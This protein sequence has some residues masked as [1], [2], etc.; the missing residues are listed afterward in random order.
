MTAA[1][2]SI[3]GIGGKKLRLYAEVTDL[4]SPRP[5]RC[6]PGVTVHRWLRV[7]D[8]ELRVASSTRAICRTL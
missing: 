3:T 6:E 5:R 4:D 1:S 8:A 2:A 7:A